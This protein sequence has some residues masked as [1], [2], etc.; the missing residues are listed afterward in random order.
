[1][2]MMSQQMS[3]EISGMITGLFGGSAYVDIASNKV[4]YSGPRGGV[5]GVVGGGVRAATFRAVP[6]EDYPTPT[7][8]I[9]MEVGAGLVPIFDPAG[10]LVTGT[11]VTGR[12]TS[13]AWAGVQ[14]G[15]DVA[16]FLFEFRAATIEARVASVAEHSTSVSLAFRPG[17]A[18]DPPVP[19]GHNMVGVNTGSGTEW[20]HLVVANAERP[21]PLIVTGG[22][23]LVVR[24]SGPAS[25]YV[26]A[27]VP[28]S[29]EEAA[30]AAATAQASVDV[31]QA[32]QYGLFCQDC[33]TYASEVLNAAGV[34]TP[35]VSTPSLNYAAALSRT[36]GV[37]A[38]LRAAAGAST[39]AS[40]GSRATYLRESMQQFV[41]SE[42]TGNQTYLEQQLQMSIPSEH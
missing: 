30:R 13:R 9:G 37:V 15:L 6:I 41:P 17:L 29:P 40:V 34:S 33:T 24:S 10:R 25:E 16:P 7:S 18:A 2:G 19:I 21:S 28:V 26:V 8:L 22:D 20:S 35:R 3:R 14:L 42:R 38:P 11:T 31:R 12:E 39:V 32:G 27:T 36:P 23:A 1:M 5:G 4:E